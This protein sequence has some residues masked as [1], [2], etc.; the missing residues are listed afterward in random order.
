MRAL[1]LLI[2]ALKR[3]A[4]EEGRAGIV[5]AAASRGPVEKV[6]CC[7]CSRGLTS[8]GC[9]W[10]RREKT[11]SEGFHLLL[12]HTPTRLISSNTTK[13]LTCLQSLL[14]QTQLKTDAVGIKLR[15]KRVVLASASARR[16]EILEDCLGWT[17]FEVIPSTFEE[18]LSHADY[19]GRELEYPVETAA[20]K[21]NVMSSKRSQ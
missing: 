9:C 16:K 15:G 8:V 5:T 7:H 18:T 3:M 6:S 11:D 17:G 21:V 14:M 19:V 20:Q 12:F 10:S 13:K 2:S 4:S 1:A